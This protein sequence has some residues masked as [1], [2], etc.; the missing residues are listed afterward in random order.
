MFFAAFSRNVF[1]KQALKVNRA[2][3]L[4][5][6]QIG[7]P[8]S[9]PVAKPT[10]KQTSIALAWQPGSVSACNSAGFES[11]HPAGF[12][13]GHYLSAVVNWVGP[14]RNRLAGFEAS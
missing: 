7:W 10:L 12:K 8:V 9:H 3:I 1:V 5:D 4:Y 2:V 13:V 6:W 11:G 14:F